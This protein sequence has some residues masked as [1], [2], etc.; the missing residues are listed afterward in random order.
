MSIVLE[1][2]Q[3]LRFLQED[4][5]ERRSIKRN[6]TDTKDSWPNKLKS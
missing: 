1:A 2:D 3:G 4:R 6:F 5:D